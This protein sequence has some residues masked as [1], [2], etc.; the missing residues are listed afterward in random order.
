MT[1]NKLL[2]ILAVIG[3]LVIGAIGGKALLH[4]GFYTSHDGEH[5]LVRQYV[6]DQ[7]LRDGQIPVR[8]SRQLY[9]GFGYPLFIF[10]YRLPFYIGEIFRIFG[11]SYAD[12]VKMTFFVTYLISGLTMYWF[13][14]RQGVLPAFLASLLYLWAPYRF[15]VMFVRAALGEHLVFIFLPIIFWAISEKKFKPAVLAGSISIAGLILSHAMMAQ[16]IMIPIIAWILVNLGS[17]RKKIIYVKKI[18]GIFILGGGI[19][20]YYLIPAMIYQSSIQKLLPFFFA[21]HFVT[22][23]QLVYSPWGYAFSMKGT[24]DDGMSFQ[25]GIAQWLVVGVA[26]LLAV[27]SLYRKRVY[28]RLFSLLAIFGISTYL[29]TDKSVF[30]WEGWRKWLNIDIPWR[31]LAVSTFTASVLA[32]WV[33]YLIKSNLLRILVVIGIIGLAIY[34]NRNHLRVNKYIDY[35][36]QELSGFRGT[37]NSF[38]EYRPRWENLGAVENRKEEFSVPIGKGEG[39]VVLNKSNELSLAVNLQDL[40]TVTFNILDFPGWDTLVDGKKIP[41]GGGGNGL[42]QAKIPEGYHFIQ[43]LWG[44]TQVMKVADMISLISCGLVLYWAFIYAKEKK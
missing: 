40:T 23:K 28:I 35:P 12:C 20:A 19:A 27:W 13:V 11:L 21:D 22:L 32:G 8:Y 24:A 43:V 25:V 30:L 39:A 33:V 1:R 41:H 9:K 26:I 3:I 38:D 5:Q 34:G 37:S 15:S 29:M 7:G 4:P 14:K 17:A 42:I 10:T 44:E 36:D 2:N 6:F 16:V 31:F 18:T